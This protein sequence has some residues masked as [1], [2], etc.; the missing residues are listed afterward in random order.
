[1]AEM[2]DSSKMSLAEQAPTLILLVWAAT[3]GWTPLGTILDR[4][5]A[6]S[7]LA[8]TRRRPV[9]EKTLNWPTLALMLPQAR[10]AL[11]FGQRSQA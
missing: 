8:R 1:M 7:T 10:L 9:R 11:T 5:L 4:M 3:P 2:L 6:P